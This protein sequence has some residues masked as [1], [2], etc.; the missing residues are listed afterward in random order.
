[1]RQ[2]FLLAEL[3]AA[4]LARLCVDAVQ[5]H[6]NSIYRGQFKGAQVVSVLPVILIPSST[7]LPSWYL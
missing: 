1:M 6:W 4:Q 5:L 7:L 2:L 3:I